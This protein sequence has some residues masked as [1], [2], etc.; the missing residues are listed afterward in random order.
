MKISLSHSSNTLC[1]VEYIAIICHFR[2]HAAGRQTYRHNIVSYKIAI[3]KSL[4]GASLFLASV[5]ECSILLAS[6][7]IENGRI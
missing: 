6:A 1:P 7:R 5:L 2:T 3:F 4:N